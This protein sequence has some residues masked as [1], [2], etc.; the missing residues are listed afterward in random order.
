L[1]DGVW[2]EIQLSDVNPVV[3]FT[4]ELMAAHLG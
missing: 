2:D 4:R 1:F 3:E